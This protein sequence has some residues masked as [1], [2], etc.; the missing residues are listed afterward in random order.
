MKDK[1]AKNMLEQL[2]KYFDNIYLTEINNVRSLFY[3]RT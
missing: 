2:K 1:N 3:R